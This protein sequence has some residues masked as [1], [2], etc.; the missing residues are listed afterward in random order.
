MAASITKLCTGCGL[1]VS[2]KPR[3]KDAQ[4]R[5]F[6]N[7]CGAKDG[8]PAA[9]KPATTPASKPMP[10]AAPMPAAKPMPASD[11]P[12]LLDPIMEKVLS[13]ALPSLPPGKEGAGARAVSTTCNACSAAMSPGATICLVCG[14]NAATGKVMRTKVLAADKGG[15]GGKGG[16]KISLGSNTDWSEVGKLAGGIFLYFLVLGF[17]V[18]VNPLFIIPLGLSMMAYGLYYLIAMIV[19]PFLEGRV[20]WG[21]YHIA[22]MALTVSAFSYAKTQNEDNAT[23]V[24]LIMQLPSLYYIFWLCENNRLKAMWLLTLIFWAA[25]FVLALVFGIA[26]AAGGGP[27]P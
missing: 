15:G 11:A 16:P 2:N 1:D 20:L 27:T 7:A 23:I 4:G 17:L 22:V 14:Y 5:Y 21:M 12:M 19:Q 13:Q 6:C 10:A 8:V 18:A 26:A 24:P 9:A 3:S 25:I